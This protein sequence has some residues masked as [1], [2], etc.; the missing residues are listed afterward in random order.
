MLSKTKTRDPLRGA[1][2]LAVTQIKPTI[3]PELSR[4]EKKSKP[5]QPSGCRGPPTRSGAKT[6]AIIIIIIIIIIIM[7]RDSSVCIAT[8]YWLDGP[9]SIPGSA[10]FFFSP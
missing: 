2:S 1:H 9:D 4:G 3:S 8:G 7:G 6:V 5:G 10:T